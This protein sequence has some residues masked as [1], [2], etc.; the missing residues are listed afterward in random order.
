MLMRYHGKLGPPRK[1]CQICRNLGAPRSAIFSYKVDDTVHVYDTPDEA[2]R[3][4][5]TLKSAYWSRAVQA[6]LARTYANGC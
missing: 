2:R 5:C 3:F 6:F 1:C 4:S